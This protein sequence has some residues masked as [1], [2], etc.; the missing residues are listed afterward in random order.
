MGDLVAQNHALYA[1]RHGYRYTMIPRMLDRH[2]PPA[3]SKVLAVQDRLESGE[4]EW[5]MWMDADVVIMNHSVLLE[6]SLLSADDRDLIV[7]PDASF[8]VSSGVW[9]IRRGEWSR[10]FLKR[11]WNLK[12]FVRSKGL[13]LSGDNKAFGYLV[14]QILED[15]NEREHIHVIPE[16]CAMNSNAVFLNENALNKKTTEWMG[17]TTYFHPGDFIAHAAGVDQKE[18]AIQLLVD[19]ANDQMAAYID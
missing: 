4:C 3:W 18:L 1:H 13:S 7:T 2:R 11:W 14:G 17:S 5:V 9:L 15:D 8:G 6:Q 19:E 10:Q 16:R 12:H